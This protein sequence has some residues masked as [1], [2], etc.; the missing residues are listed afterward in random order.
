M[1]IFHSKRVVSTSDSL[2][3]V[4]LFGFQMKSHIIFHTL[5]SF[6]WCMESGGAVEPTCLLENLDNNLK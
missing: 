6:I 1:H 5:N 2:L 4:P 3:H